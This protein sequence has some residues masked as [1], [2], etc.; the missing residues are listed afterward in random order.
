MFNGDAMLCWVS[1]IVLT[2]RSQSV[3][4]SLYQHVMSI[5]C[6]QLRSTSSDS[7]LLVAAA[8]KCILSAVVIS[9]LSPGDASWYFI[10]AGSTYQARAEPLSLFQTLNQGNNCAFISSMRI[11]E[12]SMC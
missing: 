4:R 3:R 12:I 11:A 8:F 2:M 5:T 6:V 10:C 1:A 9:M 7:I